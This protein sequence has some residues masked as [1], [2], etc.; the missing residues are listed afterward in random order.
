MFRQWS[1][2][3]FAV[4]VSML[5]FAL[6]IE[7]LAVA[8]FASL[9]AGELDWPGCNLADG[10]AAIVPILSKAPRNDVVSNDKEDDERENEESRE[11]E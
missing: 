7:H 2:A 5:A 4:H 11:S 9:V 10:R 1:V 3:C 8:S 6:H